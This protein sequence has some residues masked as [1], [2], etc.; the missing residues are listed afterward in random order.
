VSTVAS[1]MTE[2]RARLAEVCSGALGVPFLEGRIDGPVHN[3]ALGCV[4]PVNVAEDPDNV[5]NALIR[6]NVRVYQ[7]WIEQTDPERPV[8][9][10]K[11]EEWVDALRVALSDAQLTGGVWF[12]RLTNV[13][14]DV[15]DQGVELSILA[16]ADNLFGCPA[17]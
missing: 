16:F 4:Y 13:E 1:E 10:E 8:T 9:T 2:L 3:R 17:P 12:F 5:L 14:F 11:L 15:D 6:V 7:K